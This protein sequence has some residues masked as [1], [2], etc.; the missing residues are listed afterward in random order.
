MAGAT[1]GNLPRRRG[2]TAT[3]RVEPIVA[4]VAMAAGLPGLLGPGSAS[5]HDRETCGRHHGRIDRQVIVAVSM[6]ATRQRRRSHAITAVA[7]HTAIQGPTPP[8]ASIPP[9]SGRARADTRRKA[10]PTMAAAQQSGQAGC[11]R[12]RSR[13][14]R[15]MFGTGEVGRCRNGSPFHD[16]LWRFS[17]R[18]ATELHMQ[19]YCDTMG[20]TYSAPSGASSCPCSPTMWKSTSST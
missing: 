20:P 5:R 1:R 15:R 9:R 19:A 14:V 2:M 4:A 18:N 16:Q 17:F 3:E 6:S 7:L 10:T 12:S 11:R 13:W 8:I